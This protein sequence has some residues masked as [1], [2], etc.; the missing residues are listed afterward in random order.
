[1]RFVCTGGLPAKIFYM[2]LSGLIFLLGVFKNVLLIKRPSILKGLHGRSALAM[3]SL[4]GSLVIISSH[5]DIK[6]NLDFFDPHPF[7]V[8]VALKKT[9]L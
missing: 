8:P 1:M 6:V 5:E 9:R 3:F 4:I 7:S 2:I